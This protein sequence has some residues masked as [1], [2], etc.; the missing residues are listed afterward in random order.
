MSDKA[1]V[2]EILSQIY[3]LRFDSKI[4]FNRVNLR[5]S[6]CPMKFLTS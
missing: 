6:A 3:Q 1:L 2:L 4:L 5:L